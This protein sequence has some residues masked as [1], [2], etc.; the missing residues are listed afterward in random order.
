MAEAQGYEEYA[1]DSSDEEVR[2]GL[3][4]STVGGAGRTG[5]GSSPRGPVLRRVQRSQA[6]V[7]GPARGLGEQFWG[8]DTC[9]RAGV[10][11]CMMAGEGSG[12]T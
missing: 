6:T 11:V 8:Q 7:R 4:S 2:A 1:E 10:C 5:R 9:L 12:G 3:A